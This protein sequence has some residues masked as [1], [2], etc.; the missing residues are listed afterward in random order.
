MIYIVPQTRPS[1]ERGVN[2]QWTGLEWTGLTLLQEG[3]VHRQD[4]GRWYREK[5][6][7][8]GSREKCLEKSVSGGSKFLGLPHSQ[9]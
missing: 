5:Y 9:N 2:I 4:Y 7:L 6:T 1:Q 8:S 3:E